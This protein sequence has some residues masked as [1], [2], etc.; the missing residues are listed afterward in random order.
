MYEYDDAPL[1]ADVETVHETEYWTQ[2][3]VTLDAAYGDERMTLFLFLPRIDREPFQTILFFPGAGPIHSRSSSELSTRAFDFIIKSGRAVAFPV[4]KG[5]FERGSDDDGLDSGFPNETTTYRDFVIQWA[6][7]LGRSIDYIETRADLDTDRLGYYGSSWGGLIANVMLAVEDR[8]Q[9]AVLLVAGLNLQRTLPE[10]DQIN[11]VTRVTLPVLMLNGRYD[12]IF[13]LETAQIPMFQLLGTPPEHKRHVVA[14]TGHT[15][16]RN[17]LIHESLDWL[18]QY[19]GPV[20]A[21]TA[22]Q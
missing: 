12:H 2:E 19:L 5:T 14:D 22:S 3:R 15:V 6:K 1:N 21:F 7:D 13:P 17:Q 9:V 18:D 4:F 16:P 20:D 8:F 10:V 11:F